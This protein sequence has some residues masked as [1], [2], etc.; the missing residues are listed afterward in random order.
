MMCDPKNV[1]FFFF[2]NKYILQWDI[3]YYK[4]DCKFIIIVRNGCV[5]NEV[6]C[7][8]SVNSI[9]GK[10]VKKSLDCLSSAKKFPSAVTINISFHNNNCTDIDSS[11]MSRNVYIPVVKKP[12]ME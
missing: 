12:D 8:V 2:N 3:E 4:P 1:T 7:N 6:V 10:H 5:P 9:D 11:C